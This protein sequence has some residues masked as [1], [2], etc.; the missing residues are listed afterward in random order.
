VTLTAKESRAE[1]LLGMRRGKLIGV[2]LFTSPG[3]DHD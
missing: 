2:L 1:W 3:M